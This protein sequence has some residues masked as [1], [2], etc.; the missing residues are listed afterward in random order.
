MAKKRN[1]D[2]FFI[3]L[4]SVIYLFVFS[5]STSPLYAGYVNDYGNA[6]S[7]TNLLIGKGLAEG[8]IPY[9]DLFG[10]E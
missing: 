3:I 9:V 5:T 6:F 7:S 2:L 4:V 1:I 8:M 10:V